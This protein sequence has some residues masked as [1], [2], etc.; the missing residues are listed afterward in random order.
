LYEAL[1]F[2]LPTQLTDAFDS[3]Y[4]L[5]TANLGVFCFIDKAQWKRRAEERT[6]TAKPMLVADPQR[7]KPHSTLLVSGSPEVYLVRLPVRQLPFS[8]D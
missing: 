2:G 1:L 7:L 6:A 3:R 8:R 4:D 5:L